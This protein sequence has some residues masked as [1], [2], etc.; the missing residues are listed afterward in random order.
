MLPHIELNV[1]R[2]AQAIQ[3]GPL[4]NACS[5]PHGRPVV[6]LRAGPSSIRSS[7]LP[8]KLITPSTSQNQLSFEPHLRAPSN[9][10][11]S[12]NAPSVRDSAVKPDISTGGMIASSRER[13]HC[14]ASHQQPLQVLVRPLRWGPPGEDIDALRRDMQRASSGMLAASSRVPDGSLQDELI[15]QVKGHND[16]SEDATS[17]SKV[18]HGLPPPTPSLQQGRPSSSAPGGPPYDFIVGSDL[19]YYTY[20]EATPHSKLLLWTLRHVAVPGSLIYLAL[21]LHHNPEE[22]R[23]VACHP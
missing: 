10:L 19:I 1:R 20:S 3:T 13:L 12:N 6:G 9:N 23:K 21:S 2:N 15:G 4:G 8:A 18:D 7:E 16:K 5:R 17:I 22:V 11:N 14:H